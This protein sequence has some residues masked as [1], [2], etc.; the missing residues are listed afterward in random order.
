M[1]K[2]I[3][4]LKNFIKSEILVIYLVDSNYHFEATGLVIFYEKIILYIRQCIKCK[5]ISPC[6]LCKPTAGERWEGGFA[7]V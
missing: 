7:K 5:P 2:N 4:I 3:L 6:K 1:L